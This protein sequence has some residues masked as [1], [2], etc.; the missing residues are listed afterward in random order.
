MTERPEITPMTDTP[1]DALP[2]TWAEYEWPEWVPTEVR[3]S[4]EEFWRESWGR[5]PRA[6]AEGAAGPY[7]HAPCLIGCRVTLAALG[8][9]YRAE[10]GRY[11][12]C[13][14]NIGR[15]IRDDGSVAYVSNDA[16]TKPV[17]KKCGA[18]E[19][20]TNGLCYRCYC[21]AYKPVGVLT[22]K[23]ESAR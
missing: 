4:V 3:G 17:C 20:G 8:D 19:R 22:E 18:P 5:G 6:W 21:D 10:T 23:A 13:W 7:N 2:K 15:I 9:H 12:Y 14:N 11:V 1:R 16:P